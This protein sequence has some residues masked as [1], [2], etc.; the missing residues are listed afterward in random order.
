MVTMLG[1]WA[2]FPA[3]PGHARKAVGQKWP[4]TVPGVFFFFLGFRFE[5]KISEKVVNLKN[6]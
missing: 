5:L 2:G 1:T 3:G 4:G 6:V